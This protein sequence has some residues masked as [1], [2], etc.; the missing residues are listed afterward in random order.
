MNQVISCRSLAQ[1]VCYLG[2][3]LSCRCD[4][5][6]NAALHEDDCSI[7]SK[8][9]SY[10][11]GLVFISV[12]RMSDGYQVTQRILYAER[13]CDG[14]SQKIAACNL[15]IGSTCPFLIFLQCRNTID[16]CQSSIVVNL[17]D[18]ACMLCFLICTCVFISKSC[19]TVE[20]SY[21]N[22]VCRYHFVCI[23]QP[24]T[25]NC[26]VC[27]TASEE[28]H[29]A[30]YFGNSLKIEFLFSRRSYHVEIIRSLSLACLLKSG[31]CNLMSCLS[32]RSC[33]RHACYANCKFFAAHGHDSYES[34]IAGN[35]SVLSDNTC[36]GGITNKWNSRQFFADGCKQSLLVILNA[37][38]NKSHLHIFNFLDCLR[39]LFARKLHICFCA[40]SCLCI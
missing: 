32:C 23:K 33:L 31:L 12:H 1:F 30:D 38:V 9:V 15:F 40:D 34:V 10:S 26:I 21:C 27:C 36:K 4:K 22:S 29:S 39:C 7:L 25:C 11:D 20:E 35:K 13:S 24:F 16:F 6:V 28:R 37:A 18:N 5:T 19:V 17:G 2:Y 3:C 8:V 14:V